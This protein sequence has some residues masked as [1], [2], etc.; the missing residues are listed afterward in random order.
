MTSEKLPINIDESPKVEK[1]EL[2]L[3]F[4][5]EAEILSFLNKFGISGEDVTEILDEIKSGIEKIKKEINPSTALIEEYLGSACQEIFEFLKTDQNKADK[6]TSELK[7]MITGEVIETESVEA[8][9]E[10][11]ETT[12][13]ESTEKEPEVVTMPQEKIKSAVEIFRELNEAQQKVS[14]LQKDWFCLDKKWDNYQKKLEGFEKKLEEEDFTQKL[15]QEWEFLIEQI[16]H[17]IDLEQEKASDPEKIEDKKEEEKQK[18]QDKIKFLKV[19]I[20]ELK[21]VNVTIKEDLQK[22]NTSLNRIIKDLKILEFGEGLSSIDDRIIEAE[23][24]FNEL[25]A[26]LNMEDI[27]EE[28]KKILEK[29]LKYLDID[30]QEIFEHLTFKDI[31][32]L[33]KLLIQGQDENLVINF[34]QEKITSLINDTKRQKLLNKEKILD[35]AKEINRIVQESIEAEAQRNL[36]KFSMKKVGKGAWKFSK[37]FGLYFGA[38]TAIGLLGITT[39]GLGAAAGFS[40]LSLGLRKWEQKKKKDNAGKIQ[41]DFEL[42]LEREKVEVAKAIFLDAKKA[43]EKFSGIISNEIR[44]QTSQE[45]INALKDYRK[46]EMTSDEAAIEVRLGAV[47]KELYTSALTMIKAEYKDFPAEQQEHMAVAM[48][49]TLA[50]HERNEHRGRK[51]LED[52]QNNKPKIAQF[53]KKFS[54][55]RT[56]TVER[57]PAGVDQKFWDKY[58]YDA[59]ALAIGT[60]VGLAIRTSGTAR[61]AFGALTGIGLGLGS[62]ELWNDWQ[63]RRAFTKIEKMIDQ[64]EE[65]I[66]DIEFPTEELTEL[67]KN[68]ELV[69]SRF[70]LG[71]LDSN[72]ILKSRAENFI[73]NVNKLE[74]ANQKVLEDLLKQQEENRENLGKKIEED[75]SSIETKTKKNRII[76]MVGG[77]VIGALTAGALTEEGRDILNLPA[78]INDVYRHFPDHSPE[79]INELALE[80]NFNKT[81]LNAEEYLN[82]LERTQ[83]GENSDLVRGLYKHF[84]DDRGETWEVRD[85]QGEIVVIRDNN[86]DGIPDEIMDAGGKFNKISGLEDVKQALGVGQAPEFAAGAEVSTGE[87]GA[88]VISPTGGA[89]VEKAEVIENKIDSSEL[90]EGLHDSVWYSTLQMVKQS[91][92]KLGFEG[93][94]DELNKWAEQ[95]TNLLVN[96]LDKSTEGGIKDL[97]HDGDYVFLEQKGDEWEL[98]FRADS[99][100]APDY[101]P[102]VEKINLEDLKVEDLVR[103]GDV[104]WQRYLES[105]VNDLQQNQQIDLDKTEEAFGAG[106]IDRDQYNESLEIIKNRYGIDISVYQHMLENAKAKGVSEVETTTG[107]VQG[108]GIVESLDLNSSQQ[109]AFELLKSKDPT[110]PVADYEKY[111]QFLGTPESPNQEM[112]DLIMD[113]AT[114]KLEDLKDIIIYD[115][116]IER[117]LGEDFRGLNLE[118]IYKLWQAG[119]SINE[120]TVPDHTFN[121]DSS[122][123]L[124]KS[125]HLNIYINQGGSYGFETENGI[126]RGGAFNEQEEI[127]PSTLAS[128]AK[129]F[130][131]I[132]NRGTEE[133]RE[134]RVEAVSK[135]PINEEVTKASV[136]EAQVVE[137]PEILPEGQLEFHDGISEAQQEQ[138]QRHYDIETGTIKELKAQLDIWKYNY[139]DKPEYAEFEKWVTEHISQRTT[140]LN[141]VVSHVKNP[142]Y[143][144]NVDVKEIGDISPIDIADGV[145]SIKAGELGLR[146]T[147]EASGDAFDEFDQEVSKV[148]AN[149]PVIEKPAET[150]QPSEQPTVEPQPIVEQVEQNNLGMSKEAVNELQDKGYSIKTAGEM[151]VFQKGDGPEIHIG[152]DGNYSYEIDGELSQ[153]GNISTENI[154]P[155]MLDELGDKYE[156][157]GAQ[158]DLG[159]GMVAEGGQ[160][161]SADS[162]SKAEQILI[163]Q[164]PE[165]EKIITTYL[166]TPD[167]PKQDM[168]DFIVK[169]PELK[170]DVISDLRSD[171]DQVQRVLGV[172]WPVDK[173]YDFHKNNIRILE[174]AEETEGFKAGETLIFREEGEDARYY[175]DRDNNFGVLYGGEQMYKGHLSYLD[176]KTLKPE[177]LY[178]F[179][180]A[181]EKQMHREH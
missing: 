83:Q 77:A 3:K 75:I 139:G 39:A 111:E 93:K 134:G 142:D 88:E 113:N 129:E 102:E 160:E 154:N 53:L 76:G 67:R 54:A 71:L 157:L 163:N 166:G 46:V 22:I 167:A 19:Q 164:N 133:T 105:K 79:E 125:G 172:E 21:K 92:E 150:P 44:R 180:E 58:K 40:L 26:N 114:L 72:Q 135:E 132:L 73:H 33:S 178:T 158:E 138:I 152:K 81:E 116:I 52:L 43:R 37:N 27:P 29:K 165:N 110:G 140:D 25:K 16:N 14:D 141:K 153:A 8:D 118:N 146:T 34:F 115:S 177:D 175:L 23:E 15:I 151:T 9:G 144:F 84:N 131:E 62:A 104:G 97:V 119:Y 173:V 47:E 148:E 18:R 109:Q 59:A 126:I 48:A 145:L 45:S 143:D 55:W 159:T 147:D 78:N 170:M 35:T 51:R 66:R 95:Q 156:R 49:M 32:N 38:G 112:I 101:L 179:K 122:I 42:K 120:Q 24:Q 124:E 7:S 176:P 155:V 56:G 161:I 6:A 117:K 174:V 5:N 20:N 149:R 108:A 162:Y 136:K 36:M 12:K 68:S 1:S 181:F 87:L 130:Q 2:S 91:A 106:V 89:N 4:P 61:I 169:N 69:Q 86:D 99:G 63:G 168:A 100:I 98:G 31:E 11:T 121:V 50:Q 74:I 70:E 41:K 64:A 128:K 82:I 90:G 28:V 171:Q 80:L 13:D 107:A 94:D 65:V 85:T 123:V 17:K 30:P 60:G 96:N 103:K 10:T 137:R 127:F 57:K